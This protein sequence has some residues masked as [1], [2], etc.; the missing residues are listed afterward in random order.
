MQFQVLGDLGENSD[1]LISDP[2]PQKSLILTR[3][4]ACVL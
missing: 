1:S 2:D 3:G 4:L